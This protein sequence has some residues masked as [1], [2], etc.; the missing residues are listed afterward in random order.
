MTKKNS[1]GLYIDQKGHERIVEMIT[2]IIDEQVMEALRYGNVDDSEIKSCPCKE[3]IIVQNITNNYSLINFGDI[4]IQNS[5]K[6]IP[7]STNVEY[8]VL[9]YKVLEIFIF[10]FLQIYGNEKYKIN[11]QVAQLS[12]V[13]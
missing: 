9:L 4:K 8:V 1:K 10:L 6:Y 11:R 3:K 7:Y 12:Y 5:L 13:A 2:A